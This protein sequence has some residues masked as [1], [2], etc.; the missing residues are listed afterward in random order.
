[1]LD[2]TARQVLGQRLAVLIFAEI[3]VLPHFACCHS[4]MR[5]GERGHAG[6]GTRHDRTWSASASSGGSPAPPRGSWSMAGRAPP[7]WHRG[8]AA[9]LRANSFNGV[10]SAASRT[11]LRLSDVFRRSRAF[12][13]FATVIVSANGGTCSSR[14]ENEA[15]L[16]PGQHLGFRHDQPCQRGARRNGCDLPLTHSW[17]LSHAEFSPTTGRPRGGRQNRA[18]PLRARASSRCSI[19]QPSDGQGRPGRASGCPCVAACSR[20]ARHLPVASGGSSCALSRVPAAIAEMETPAAR[21]CA[22]SSYR[23]RR[24]P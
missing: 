20:A 19:L 6:V 16:R 17:R 9:G 4:V 8:R 1:M 23:L 14:V 5:R 11:A 15:P 2:L 13:R 3:W 10:R 18:R 7:V 22:A 21:S 12:S 24:R